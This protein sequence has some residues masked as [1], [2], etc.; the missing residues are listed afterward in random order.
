MDADDFYIVDY[1]QKDDKLGLSFSIGENRIVLDMT[2]ELG[3]VKVVQPEELFSLQKRLSLGLL[4]LQTW[5]NS[6]KH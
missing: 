1:V 4:I 6:N 2:N 3:N 5:K